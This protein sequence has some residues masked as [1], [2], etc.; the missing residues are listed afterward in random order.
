MFYPGSRFP[1]ADDL[2]ETYLR[3]LIEAHASA[4]E[5]VVA[6]QGG[7]STMMGLGFF[8]RPGELARRYRRPGQQ[9][10]YTIQT[11]GTLLDDDWGTFF[12]EHGFLVGL[13]I[14]GPAGIHDTYRAGKG[15]KGSFG[16]VMKGLG[17]LQ[18]HG[19]QWNA[20][21]QADRGEQDDSDD[22]RVAAHSPGR[23]KG[24]GPAGPG[25]QAGLRTA[26]GGPKAVESSSGPL[27]RAVH[28]FTVVGARWDAGCE[29]A[30]RGHLTAERPTAGSTGR[31]L[32]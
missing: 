15:G 6:W 30:A 11:N 2:P 27:A 23:A 8:R 19:V 22:H 3:Q 14:D 16:R 25:P 7:E 12:A 20:L 4:P 18:R 17:V 9:I 13:P 21:T 26:P 24:L 5:V 29:G 1:M 31:S 10:T 32:S 28:P